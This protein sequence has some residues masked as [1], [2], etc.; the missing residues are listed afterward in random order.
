MDRQAV[1]AQV[2]RQAI[3]QS[4][5][6]IL[7]LISGFIQRNQREA[8]R[9]D[10]AGGSCRHA[11]IKRTPDDRGTG[12]GQTF[13][14]AQNDET[15]IGASQNAVFMHRA[16]GGKRGGD[17]DS[18]GQPSGGRRGRNPEPR[19]IEAVSGPEQ[20]MDSFKPAV[21]H[22]PGA[23]TQPDAADQ[24]GASDQDLGR[25]KRIRPARIDLFAD[26]A[27]RHAQPALPQLR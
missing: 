4:R 16:P 9:L 26:V 13:G 6:Q 15:S 1:K 7:F 25:K 17:I 24:P 21:A 8:G 11:I 23:C 27:F 18:T 19:Q 10:T 22:R 5:R 20:R 3:G 14:H 2:Q 12:I